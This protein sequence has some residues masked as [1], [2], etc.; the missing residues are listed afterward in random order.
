MGTVEARMGDS[1]PLATISLDLDDKWSYMRTRGDA[2]WQEFPSYLQ[3]AVPRILSFLAPRNLRLTF[4][5]VGHDAAR[6]QNQDLLRAIVEEGHELGNH[7]Y[8]HEPWLQRYTR[9]D[10]KLEVLATHEE[11]V[12]ITG[13]APV[14]FRGPGFS[15]SPSLIEV[16]AELD[17]SFDAS[18]LPTVL[19]PLARAYFLKR[20]TLSEEERRHREGLF[21]TFRDGLRPVGPHFLTANGR[22]VVEIPVTTI[23]GL[24]TPFHLSYLMYLAEKSRPLMRAYFELALFLCRATGTPP[25]FLLHPLDFLDV[26]DA[27]ELAFFPAMRVRWQDK[28]DVADEVLGRLVSCYS[29]RTMGEFAQHL[30]KEKL[31]VL[32]VHTGGESQ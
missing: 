12:R 19:A 7:S 6:T 3:V 17:Y 27:P 24:R 30:R 1:R 9:E 8:H 18:S 23:P 14:G 26:E 10:I 5:V 2:R 21:G 13:T 15:W 32:A 22:R 29:L 11:L 31:P 4:F 25:S 20:S 28:L 16:L